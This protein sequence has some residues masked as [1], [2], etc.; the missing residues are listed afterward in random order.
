MVD[1][2]SIKYWR[3]F[4]EENYYTPSI[5]MEEI[6][7]FQNNHL[8]VL[9]DDLIPYYLGG[10][11]AR[12]AFFYKNFF[13]KNNIDCVMTY[14]TSQSNHAR[15][16]ALLASELNI[17]SFLIC[18]ENDNGD[19][20]NSRIRTLAE[21]QVINCQISQVK[22]T[23]A[24][25]IS[26]LKIKYS[27]PYFI[28]GGGHDIYGTS[29][30]V[31]LMFKIVDWEKTNNIFFDNIYFASGTGST[32]AGLLIGDMITRNIIN[33]KH[34]INGISIAR[35]KIKGEAA[36]QEAIDEFYNSYSLN[37][38]K[39]NIKFNTNYVDKGYGYISKEVEN[40]MLDMLLRYQLPLDPTYTGKAFFGMWN[41]LKKQK[42]NNIL[43][44][45]TGGT[46]LFYDYLA[47][48][49]K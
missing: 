45:H 17:D 4:S 46:P 42:N 6:G 23:I 12:K 13:I 49:N 26:S 19:N 20:N 3:L 14:G 2:K 22:E 24:K 29:A 18:P 15:S 32:Q 11:K 35:N 7:D 48:G 1:S 38:D 28:P 8:F 40:L 21:T 37:L 47:L 9:R 39:P 25:K 44:I 43:F 10:N 31:D 36:I 34:N 5:V 41:E 30:L 16:I 33:Q 27:N